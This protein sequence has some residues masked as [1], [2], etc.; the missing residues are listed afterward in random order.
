MYR[1]R[2]Q[3]WNRC[4]ADHSATAIY[5]ADLGCLAIEHR[6]PLTAIEYR[7][8]RSFHILAVPHGR[9]L[10]HES[11]VLVEHRHAVAVDVKDAAVR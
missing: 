11:V 8:A 1:L 10:H 7:A 6:E 9:M 5:H 2:S 3:I 4:P